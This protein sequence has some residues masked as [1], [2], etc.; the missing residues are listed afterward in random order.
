[1]LCL[2]FHNFFCFIIATKASLRVVTGWLFTYFPRFASCSFILCFIFLL[3]FR[4]ENNL[5]FFLKPK[6][7]SDV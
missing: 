5:E 6:N 4:I 3:H 2:L 1:M 7:V